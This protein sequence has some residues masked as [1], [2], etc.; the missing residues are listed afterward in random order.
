MSLKT[1]RWGVLILNLGTPQTTQTRDVRRYLT[2]FLMD[3][4]VIDFPWIFR[5]LLVYG[6]IAPFRSPKS[7][8]L[9]KKV[10]TAQGSPLRV[11]T[12]NFVDHLRMDFQEDPLSRQM[13]VPVAWAFRY[14]EPSLEKALRELREQK[15]ERIMVMPMYP[16][17]AE[18]S[19]LTSLEQLKEKLRRSPFRGVKLVQHYYN[20]DFYIDALVDSVAEHKKLTMPETILLSYHSL[21]VRHITKL[22]PRCVECSK[23][24][25]CPSLQ[26]ELC[27]RGQSYETSKM[28]EKKLKERF[29]EWRNVPVVTTFQSK[30]TREPWLTPATDP[31]IGE[32]ATKGIKKLMVIAP[33]FSVDCLETL[34][35][36]DMGLQE[37]FHSM[38]GEVFD[39]IP[40]LNADPQW[41][42]KVQSYLKSRIEEQ[43]E[44]ELED[45][46]HAE[47][48]RAAAQKSTH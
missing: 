39:R 4:F 12:Q 34:E 26:Y 35:E 22:N 42:L 15:V 2:E 3:P 27:Y 48:E 18:S 17:Y 37:K 33:G 16:Q 32:L 6:I 44:V 19:T 23:N 30:L 21:P 8:A 47:N 7:A 36:L 28:I 38:G 9:Y 5:A 43:V 14:G 25:K 10:W 20:Q 40:C 31:V 1:S 11:L 45:L 46:Q 29:P 13:D 24:P 41:T